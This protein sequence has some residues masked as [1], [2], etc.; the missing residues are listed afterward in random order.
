M[1]ISFNSNEK[2]DENHVNIFAFY[3]LLNVKKR[4]EFELSSEDVVSYFKELCKRFEIKGTILLSE[5]G[6]N[7]TIAGEEVNVLDFMNFLKKYFRINPDNKFESLRSDNDNGVK[8]DDININSDSIVDK[9]EFKFS[10]SGF[11]PFSKMKVLKRSEVVSLKSDIGEINEDLKPID[12]SGESWDELLDDQTKEGIQLID[13]RNDYEYKIGTFNGSINPCIINFREFKTYVQ[14]S[15]N[16]GQLK[17]NVPCAIF[18]TGGIRCEKAGIYMRNLGFE[19][20]YQLKGGILKYFE[21]TKNAKKKWTGDCFVFDDRVSV[22]DKLEP[23]TLRCIH[24][25]NEI[26]TIEEKRSVTKGR[27]ECA[28][29]LTE[30]QRRGLANVSQD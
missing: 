10:Y 21:D 26:L 7:G 23:G 5:E 8:S 11:I 17:K 3:I 9:F 18:C 2:T 15:L 27:V 30:K 22:N 12:L 24:C 28:K 14:N 25:F 6:V 13:A 1:N 16:D 4:L 19:K 29:C 20:V